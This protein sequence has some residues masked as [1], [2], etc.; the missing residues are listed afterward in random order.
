[1]FRSEYCY[2]SHTQVGFAVANSKKKKEPEFARWRYQVKIDVEETKLRAENCGFSCRLLEGQPKN[3]KGKNGCCEPYPL[4]EYEITGGQLSLNA[5][6]QIAPKTTQIFFFG[7]E[8]VKPSKITLEY[9]QPLIERMKI[10]AD[11]LERAEHIMNKLAA[12][13]DD[14]KGRFGQASR[15]YLKIP[16][17]YRLIIASNDIYQQLLDDIMKKFW[18]EYIAAFDEMLQGKISFARRR[19]DDLLKETVFF[20]RSLI[21]TAKEMK[22]PRAE[23]WEA[24]LNKMLMEPFGFPSYGF[25]RTQLNNMQ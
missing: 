21:A 4:P 16:A 7:P 6:I 19:M 2:V 20:Y 24:D 18:N 8:L 3:K 22:D 5:K 1:M 23:Q 25:K 13:V 15:I 10:V 9:L 11:D 17:M 12:F 14:E